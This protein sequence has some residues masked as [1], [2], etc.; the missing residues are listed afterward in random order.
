MRLKTTATTG[1]I[2]AALIASATPV[3]AGTA[4]AASASTTT[5]VTTQAAA[6]KK[7]KTQ[8]CDERH[9]VKVCI[10]YRTKGNAGAKTNQFVASVKSYNKSSFK[11]RLTV[12]N[13]KTWHNDKYP[14]VKRDSYIEVTKATKK[15]GHAC[16]ALYVGP[17]ASYPAW[18]A[19]IN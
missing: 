9:N 5:A 3:L 17:S 2:T 6:A 4:T 14:T 11:A 7:L 10:T 12:T 8:K 19:C 1:L 13:Q 18:M 15:N 16:A